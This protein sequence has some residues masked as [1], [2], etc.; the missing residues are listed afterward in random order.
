MMRYPVWELM[1]ASGLLS[2]TLAGCDGGEATLQPPT[3]TASLLT[4]TVT[5][6]PAGTETGL[7]TPEPTGIVTRTPLPPDMYAL[8]SEQRP[9]TGSLLLPFE[10]EATFGT[11]PESLPAGDYIVYLEQEERAVGYASLDGREK[12]VLLGV[13]EGLDL[14]DVFLHDSGRFVL[15]HF[16]LESTIYDLQKG[17]AWRVGPICLWRSQIRV[18]SDGRW[19]AAECEDMEI[20]GERK[21]H[22]VLE[23]LSTEDGRGF[24]VAVPREPTENPDRPPY[25]FWL[26]KTTLLV[27][28]AWIAEGFATCSLTVP[29]NALYCPEVF[30]GGNAPSIGSREPESDLVALL[31]SKENPWRS[32]LVSKGCFRVGGECPGIIDLTE[33]NTVPIVTKDPSLVWWITP[34]EPT[35]LSRIGLYEAPTWESRQVAEYGGSYWIV[36]QCPDGKCLFLENLDSTLRYRLDLD[37]TLTAVPYQEI[38]GTFSIP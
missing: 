9:E 7:P 36:A 15:G 30:G 33:A 8:S 16:A 1:A 22:T 28:D 27:W 35:E 3:K 23:I 26:D 10:G 20:G 21:A 37:G 19:I 13:G 2:L 11:P 18:S 38:I 4:A 17:Q 24:R 5:Q 25:V 6:M 12:G 29:A 14:P 31:Y 34:L 32:I